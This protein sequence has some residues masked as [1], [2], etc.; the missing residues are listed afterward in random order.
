[1]RPSDSVW[2]RGNGVTRK[3]GKHSGFIGCIYCFPSHAPVS[4]F[5]WLINRAFVGRTFAWFSSSCGI[6][7]FLKSKALEVLCVRCCEVGDAVVAEG[8]GEAGVYDVTEASGGFSGPFPERRGDVGFVV[9]VFPGGVGAEGGA[10]GGGFGGCFGLFE[11]GGVADLHV[12]FHEDEA[13]EEESLLARGFGGK[14]VL[15]GGVMGRV[16]VGRVEEEVGIGGENHEAERWWM[17]SDS[18]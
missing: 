12:D 2:K 4:S 1:M 16:G 6:P 18:G 10:E 14:E 17:A 5:A 15:R 7:Y 8:E 11:D 9:G 3:N 13:A